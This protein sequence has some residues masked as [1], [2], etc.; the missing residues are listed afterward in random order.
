[1]RERKWSRTERARD[2]MEREGGRDG[3]RREEMSERETKESGR[4]TER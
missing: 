3:E 2:E 1:M 4:K